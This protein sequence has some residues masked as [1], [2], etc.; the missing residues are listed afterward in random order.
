M[1]KSLLAFAVLS[2]IAATSSAQPTVTVYGLVDM[3]LMRESGA[4]AG[5][6]T[7]ISSGVASGSRI[8]FKGKE[9]LGGGLS[10]IFLLE[11]GF[12]GDTG[13]AGQGGLLF[14]RQSYMGLQGN[15]GTVTMGRQYT[16]QYLT[17]VM[18]DPFGSGMGGDT[19]NMFPATG[20][21]SRADN[22]ILYAS[23]VVNGINAELMY[24]PGEIP[25]S[26]SAGRQL[27]GALGYVNG[28]LKVRLGYHYRDNDTALVKNIGAAKNTVL[29]AVYNFGVASAHLAYATNKG[30]NS[31]PL[32]NPGNPFGYAVAPVAS[33]DSQD[34]LVGV[35][36]PLGSHV[37]LASYIRKDDKTRLD[38]NANQTTIG[39]RYL[40]SKRTDFYSS[41]ARIDNMNGAGYTI[42]NASE[43]GT[44]DRTF[45][46]GIRHLF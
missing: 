19:K 40:L 34:L 9:D 39:Y 25:G 44:G 37:L 46:V 21:G 16:P 35:T 26:S 7:K 5:P 3:A 30:F 29:A 17:V 22:S 12:Q 1:K 28:P 36:I 6:S 41:Y 11:N 31:S 2:A 18:V 15:W 23:P 33:V 8:G 38:Q 10:A 4:A 27:G 45:S 42:G 13:T 24:A 14:G 43:I 20:S 32:R